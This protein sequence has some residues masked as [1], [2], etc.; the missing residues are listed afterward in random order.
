[1]HKRK[2]S[3]IVFDLGNVL[4]P[5]D[6]NEIINR[7]DEIEIGLG[8][9][10]YEL[11][12]ANY[13]IHRQHERADIS[14]DE[15]ISVMLDWLDNKIDKEEFCQIYGSLFEVNQNV[16][17][18][19]P[20]LKKKYRLVL[21]SNTNE[22]HKKYGWGKY[23]FL[24]NFEKLILSHEVKA[25]KPEAA[26][27]K[28]VEHFTKEPPEEHIFIDDIKEYVEAAKDLRWDGIHFQDY[29]QLISELKSKCIL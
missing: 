18:L 1:L 25:I 15:F 17:D 12:K 16:I 29:S 2:Y 9:K 20:Q 14:G 26:I 6:Y 19:L 23:E 10:F 7:I 5:F 3:V 28:A 13:H 22:I 8:K 11:Y 27:Y 4:I 21:L 24:Q